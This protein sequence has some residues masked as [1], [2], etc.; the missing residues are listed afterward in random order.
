MTEPPK[1]PRPTQ[2][3]K[4]HGGPA[5]GTGHRMKPAGDPVSDAAR[6]KTAG[7][8]PGEGKRRKIA[9]LLEER[10]ARA[11][12]ADAWMAILRD[13]SH[14]HHATMIDKAANR[15]DGAPTQPV[16]GEGGGPVLVVT[17]VPRAE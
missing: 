11:V 4:G 7:V 15:L 14:P 6:A 1:R 17:G 10:D 9:E 2:F 13:P 16:S 8:K 5:K 12:V 3:V